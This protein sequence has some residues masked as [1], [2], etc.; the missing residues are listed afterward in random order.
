MTSAI[1]L[2]CAAVLTLGA[3]SDPPSEPQRP[4]VVLIIIDTL[5]ADSLSSYGNPYNPSPA[6]S[7]LSEGGVQFDSVLAQASWT[8]PSVGSMLTSRAPRTI[9]LYDELSVLLEDTSTLGMILQGAG[10]RTFGATA[11]PN[12]NTRSGLSRGF[13]EYVDSVVV[14]ALG[15]AT[16]PEGSTQYKR[17]AELHSASDIFGKALD[18]VDRNPGDAPTFLQ[19]NVMEVHEHNYPIMLRDEYD[20]G[21]KKSRNTNYLRRVRQVTDDMERFVIELRSRAGWEDTLFCIVSDHGE[22]LW[23]HPTVPHSAG[24]GGLLYESQVSV[25]WIMFNDSWTPARGRIAQDVRLLEF[26]PTLLDYVGVAAPSDLE[27]V[28][29]LPLIEGE[30][31]SAPLPAVMVTE[32]TFRN[33]WKISARGANWQYVHNRDKSEGVLEHELQARGARPNG[34]MTDEGQAHPKEMARLRRFID[35]WERAHAVVVPTR[36]DL[37]EAERL[38]LEQIGYLR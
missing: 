28:S 35:D 38:Q 11:N 26:L 25:P 5:R 19:L 32:T 22:G 1:L 3:C 13:D 27:G 18:F 29:L 36:A 30:V 33:F 37:S 4:N 24:H 20:F 7:R 2:S 21:F 31:E 23:D 6:L 12:L 9:G 14:F 17:G 16:V 10:Y 34:E 8:L 15:Q